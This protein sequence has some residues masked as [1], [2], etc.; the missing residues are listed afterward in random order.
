MS[1]A[2]SALGVEASLYGVA[3]MLDNVASAVPV[4]TTAAHGDR[5]PL[6][7]WLDCVTVVYVDGLTSMSS[8]VTLLEQLGLLNSV[9]FPTAGG[10]VTF[11][12][13]VL[14]PPRGKLPRNTHPLQVRGCC[15]KSSSAV[16]LLELE[17]REPLRSC[18]RAC[19]T[20]YRCR[21]HD[22]PDWDS[23]RPAPRR[24]GGAA[25]LAC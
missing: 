25:V 21:E 15:D 20:D 4:A 11:E 9:A 24:P 17:R 22:E 5:G 8:E 7:S 2:D 19:G 1:T 16:R 13:T 14:L 23:W 12:R 10:F 6:L 3:A 18:E